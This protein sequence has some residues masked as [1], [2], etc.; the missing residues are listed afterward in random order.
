MLEGKKT[1]LKSFWDRHCPYSSSY[2]PELDVTDE[3][4]Q[5]LTKRFQQLIGVLRWSIELGRIEIITE[6]SFLSQ[7]LCFPCEGRLNYVIR[8]SGTYRIIYHRI[9]KI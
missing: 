9:Q 7:N 2:R 3:L 8:F 6:V 5:N 4:A 1:V